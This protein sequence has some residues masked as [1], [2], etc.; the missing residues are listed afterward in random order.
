MKKAVKVFNILAII[1]MLIALIITLIK[2]FTKW[3]FLIGSADGNVLIA[4]LAICS[5]LFLIISFI[6]SIASKSDKQNIQKSVSRLLCIIILCFLS[7]NKI[8]EKKD[9]KYFE[10]TSPDGNYTVVAEE[11]T[12]LLSGTIRFYERENMLFVSH[13]DI[14][15]T[16]DG[17]RPI[18][19]DRYSVE[20]NDNVMTFTADNGNN[21]FKSIQIEC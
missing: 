13:K 5:A 19:S 4:I 2:A 11:K 7:F 16:D 21:I 1:P 17:Y 18:T 9:N 20:W 12:E 14:F 8:S 6:I 3:I 15:S 10:F